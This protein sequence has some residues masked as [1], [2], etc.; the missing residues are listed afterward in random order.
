MTGK[1]GSVPLFISGLSENQGA[2]E[3]KALFQKAIRRNFPKCDVCGCNLLRI[4]D[5]ELNRSEY[6]AM[7]CVQPAKAALWAIQA[8]DGYMLDGRHLRVRR[9]QTRNPL[10]C[11]A[12]TGA[13]DPLLGQERRRERLKIDLV[14]AGRRPWLSSV[15]NWLDSSRFSRA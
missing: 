3:I 15:S 13:A 14:K 2:D 12:Q 9:Y 5:Q 11:K 1:N 6:H 4:T 7:L 8:M 10:R